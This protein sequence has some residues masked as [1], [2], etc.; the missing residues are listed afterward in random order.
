MIRKN[1]IDIMSVKLIGSDHIRIH[2][3]VNNLH[4]TVHFFVEDDRLE[5]YYNEPDRYIERLAQYKYVLTPDYSL[6]CEMPMAIQMDNVFRSHWCGA[7]WQ[8]KGLVVIPTVSWSTK[9][10][11]EF[12][13]KGIEKGSVVAISTVGALKKKE[14][15]L[16][17][18]FLMKELINPSAVLCYGKPFPEMGDEVVYINYLQQTGRQ[19][20]GR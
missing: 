2:E 14:L 12:C 9:K 1:A 16:D 20:N 8:E 18:Y 5:K 11:F 17:G 4:K 3:E 6:Y 10:S 19:C 7:Y 13:F 15:L